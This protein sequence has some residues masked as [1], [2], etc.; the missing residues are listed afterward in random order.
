[1]NEVEATVDEVFR[2]EHGLVLAS[3]VK[4][5]G[6]FDLAEESLAEAAATAMETWAERGI[7]ENPAAWLLTVARNKAVDR[8]RR[9]KVLAGKL[10]LLVE[11]P[12]SEDDYRE[13]SVIPDERLALMFACCH[14]ALSPEA[15][16]AL[17]LKALGGLT[18]A[19]IARAFVTSEATMFQR[20]TRAKRKIRLAG[21]P[22]EMPGPDNLSDRLDAVLA[23]IYLIFNEGYSPIGGD[24]LTRRDLCRD[25]IRLAETMTDLMPEEAEVW[26]LAALCWLTDARRAARLDDSGDKVLL[27]DQDRS[28]WDGQ[29]IDRGLAHLTRGRA[30]GDG[31][32]LIQAGIAA[33]HARSRSW[34][35]SD[36][37]GIVGAYGRL[38]AVKPSP[39]VYLNLA[40]AVAFRDGPERGLAMMEELAEPLDDYQPFHASRAELAFRAGMVDDAVVWFSRAL[41]FPLN[42]PDRRHLE[43]RLREC[44]SAS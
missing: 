40:A 39:V 17:T 26:G 19:E 1:M 9:Q 7:P 31:P 32:Y 37:D 22:V 6:D 43:R 35:E 5:F 28:L 29:A 12:Q 20:I 4:S 18:T 8:L 13:D 41:E 21:I 38:L 15:R 42:G 34:A 25:A 11:T 2:R 44:S 3:L 27:E 24:D 30:L 23:V 36:F 33:V 14:P 16:V 10:A